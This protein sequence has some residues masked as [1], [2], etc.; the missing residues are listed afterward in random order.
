M[1]KRIRLSASPT[2][3]WE[4]DWTKCCLC[5]EDT[6]EPLKSSDEGYRMLGKNIPLF[7]EANALPIPLDI[8]RLDNGNGIE[9]TLKT[10]S[11]K[12]HNLCRIKFNN[13]KLERV[14]KRKTSSLP[15][16]SSP[17]CSS[18]KFLRSTSRSK[19]QQEPS[20]KLHICFIC[21]KESLLTALRQAMT[22]KLNRRI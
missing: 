10:K 6:V 22:R 21:E 5:Q 15:S 14:Q 3:S 8:R 2:D 16:G 20:V 1:A 11:A 9:N 12:Y 4:T 13:T 17:T 18:P 7:H 19:D